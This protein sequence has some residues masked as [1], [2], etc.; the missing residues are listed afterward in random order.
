[1]FCLYRV[2]R[3]LAEAFLYVVMQMFSWGC[4]RTKGRMWIGLKMLLWIAV[5]VFGCCYRIF[6]EDSAEIVCR[7][8]VEDLQMPWVALHLLCCLYMYFCR[9][10]EFMYP[11]DSLGAMVLNLDDTKFMPISTKP[12]RPNFPNL[13]RKQR[14]PSHQAHKKKQPMM[15]NHS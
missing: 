8:Y 2:C 9:C 14:G 1:M 11:S 13:M 4:A 6:A 12:N 5:D 10:F 7:I 15:G 3:I